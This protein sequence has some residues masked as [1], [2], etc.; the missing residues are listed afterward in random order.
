MIVQEIIKATRQ[1]PPEE[2]RQLLLALEA[3]VAEVQVAQSELPVTKDKELEIRERRMKWFKAN[4]VRYGGQYV[5]MDEDRL[6]GT[7]HSYREGRELALSQGVA[8][9][10][11]DY[12]SKPDEEGEMGG[13]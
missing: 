12:L 7:A 9:A 1:L 13:W 3:D 11:I 6:L 10:F 2:K 8:D 5:V 4:Q